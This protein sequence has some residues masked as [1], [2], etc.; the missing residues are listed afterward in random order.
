MEKVL[1]TGASG[2]LGSYV[3]AELRRRDIPAVAWSHRRQGRVSGVELRPVDLCDPD[4]VDRALQADSPDAAIHCAALSAIGDC[5]RDPDKADRLNRWATGYLGASLP[6]LLGVSTD[7]VF[8]GS[9]APYG[10]ADEPRPL[11]VYG[12]S[13]LAGERE[14]QGCDNAAVIRVSLLYG[15]ALF[16]GGFFQQQ[17]DSLSAGQKLRLFADEWRTPLALDEAASG[18]VDIL[19]SGFA[20]LAHLGGAERLSRYQMGVTLAKHLMCPEKLVVRTSQSDVNFP[21]PRPHDVS[22]ACETAKIEWGWSPSSY[23]EGLTRLI[24]NPPS[25]STK[26]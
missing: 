4:S 20:G 23:A 26:R 8:D 10:E 12:R 16:G 18:L 15:P 21:E 13:K 9:Q 17:I 24:G 25:S 1:V 5:Y 22:L 6:R 7:L 19:L 11:S 3:V 14:L 2:K